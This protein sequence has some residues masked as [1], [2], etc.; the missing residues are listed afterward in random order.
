MTE[1]L[2]EVRA[3]RGEIEALKADPSVASPLRQSYGAQAGLDHGRDER[4]E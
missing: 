1:L 3:L 2:S 4:R